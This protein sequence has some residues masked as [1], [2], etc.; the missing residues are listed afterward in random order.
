MVV[1]W[2]T[3]PANWADIWQFEG[4]EMAIIPGFA[5]AG[6]DQDYLG[7]HWEPM[8]YDQMRPGAY[9]QKARLADMDANHTDASFAFPTFPRFCGQT[10]LENPDRE[11]GL[12]C[13]QAYNDWMIDEWCAGDGY[14]RLIP[15]DAHPPLGPG[16]RRRR[17]APM[18][19]Q[20]VV[21]GRVLREPGQAAAAEH[22][23]RPLGSVLRRLR[24]DATPS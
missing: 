9:E 14:G 11:L 8:T 5:A 10:F 19:G 3:R 2:P 21:R 22:P 23:H 18:R 15:H 7:E 13:V 4:Y 6:M 1:G 24:R 12:A 16:A 20:G 17:G